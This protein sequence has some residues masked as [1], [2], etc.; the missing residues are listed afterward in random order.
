MALLSFIYL[1]QMVLRKDSF[2]HLHT[3]NIHMLVFNDVVE[4]K[5]NKTNKCE[6]KSVS[7]INTFVPEVLLHSKC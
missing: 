7:G 3:N 1:H 6:V 5:S 4:Y 2:I